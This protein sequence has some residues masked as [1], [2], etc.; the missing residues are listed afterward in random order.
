M[1]KQQDKWKEA[2]IKVYEEIASIYNQLNHDEEV[3]SMLLIIGQNMRDH[4]P[5]RRK[6]GRKQRK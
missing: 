2:Y 1:K 4:M 3:Q 5:R 6:V